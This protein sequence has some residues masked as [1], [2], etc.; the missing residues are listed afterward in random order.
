MQTFEQARQ[1]KKRNVKLG[2]TSLYYSLYFNQL[3]GKYWCCGSIFNLNLDK[4]LSQELMS[5]FLHTFS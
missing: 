4:P 5:P 1:R 3:S 2:V